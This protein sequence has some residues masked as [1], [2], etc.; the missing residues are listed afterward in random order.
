MHR[1]CDSETHDHTDARTIAVPVPSA[2]FVSPGVNSEIFPEELNAACENL[3][4]SVAS[5]TG[6]SGARYPTF[7]IRQ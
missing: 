7:Q 6:Y 1:S 5:G 2:S 3:N 4:K